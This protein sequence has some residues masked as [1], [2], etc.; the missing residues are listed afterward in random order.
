MRKFSKKPTV[1]KLCAEFEELGAPDTQ[2]PSR[3][4]KPDTVGARSEI[5]KPTRTGV[6][7]SRKAS[8]SRSRGS[9]RKAKGKSGLLS[10]LRM[11]TKDPIEYF[12]V[13]FVKQMT[14]GDDQQQTN[15]P[16]QYM[17][18][19]SIASMIFQPDTPISRVCQNYQFLSP[20][21]CSVIFAGP[22][23]TAVDAPDTGDYRLPSALWHDYL[24]GD[25]ISPVGTIRPGEHAMAPDP[26]KLF[27]KI[28]LF[29][30]KQAYDTTSDIDAYDWGYIHVA[31][32]NI[33][34]ARQGGAI[35]GYLQL[36]CKFYMW[37]AG[38]IAW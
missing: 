11:Q 24:A 4:K 1:D 38:A 29:G 34:N 23:M 25:H 20:I 18:Y 17:A 8:R 21:S 30:K 37:G 12:D 9:Y 32:A 19:A 16:R 22:K 3:I 5:I 2:R 36:R 10:M 15:E 31:F 26:D 13:T 33:G 27:I 35:Y 6:S 14:W 28:K 7:A